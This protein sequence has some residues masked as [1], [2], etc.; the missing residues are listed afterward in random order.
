MSLR[1][2]FFSKSTILFHD[3][4]KFLEIQFPLKNM[5]INYIFLFVLKKER[6]IKINNEI[7][8]I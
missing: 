4:Y 5:I 6:I 8:I 2:R 1:L 7:K 3:L